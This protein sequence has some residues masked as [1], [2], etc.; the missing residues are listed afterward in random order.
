MNRTP[1]LAKPLK[2]LPTYRKEQ[3]ELALFNPINTCWEDITSLPSSLRQ[4]LSDISWIS[5]TS[6]CVLESKRKDTFKG[7]LETTDGKRIESVVMKNARGHWTLCVSS[8]VGCAMNCS[9]CATG[10]MGFTR[11]LTTDEI[12]DQYRFFLYFLR[13]RNDV[14]NKKITNI[15]YMGMGEPLA[16]Y[17]N[18]KNSLNAILKYTDIG[19]TR[20][21]VSTVGVLPQMKKLLLDEQWPDVRIAIS[22]HSADQKIRKNIVPSTANDFFDQLAHWM[23]EAITK[24]PTR[25]NHIT[26][27]YILIENVNERKED[28]KKLIHFAQT[29]NAP[30]KINLIPY[31]KTRGNPFS[32][33]ALERQIAFQKMLEYAGITATIRRPMGDDI[34]AACGQLISESV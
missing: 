10:K 12:I 23:R 31:N 25:R 28:A 8:Q 9:F 6:Y 5:L 20:I 29:T 18:V 30:I 27:E 15:V 11:N 24:N 17:E 3:I 7:V 26:F 14:P 1:E 2:S 32:Q 13:N 16:N 22:L 34:A 33:S 19:H 21:T 4:N